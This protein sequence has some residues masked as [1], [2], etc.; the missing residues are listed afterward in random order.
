MEA[1]LFYSNNCSIC[2]DLS[3]FKTYKSIDK[4]CIDSLKVK[5]KLPKYITTVPTITTKQNGNIQIY[6][7]ADVKKWFDMVDN[8]N[9]TI[10]TISNN[11]EP[12]RTMPNNNTQP[13][14]STHDDNSIADFYSGDNFSSNFSGLEGENSTG[15]EGSNFAFINEP[16]INTPN[17]SS[18]NS[19]NNSSSNV[20][21]T[22]FELSME[23]M[24]A[25][26]GK[27]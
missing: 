16:E 6:K 10:K 26:R 1:V 22:E 2:K 7:G 12:P 23:K 9:T 15:F 4:I 13:V 27:I 5:K 3:I 11:T 14:V 8:S 21:K 20:N 17:D 18:N 25:E 19:S 24:I